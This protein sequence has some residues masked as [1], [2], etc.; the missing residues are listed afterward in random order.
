M[1]GNVNLSLHEADGHDLNFTSLI[2]TGGT[3]VPYYWNVLDHYIVIYFSTGSLQWVN[4]VSSC[5][6]STF[7]E[8]LSTYTESFLVSPDSPLVWSTGLVI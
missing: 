2:L 6:P 4:D 5:S 3:T 1:L 8:N 7:Y